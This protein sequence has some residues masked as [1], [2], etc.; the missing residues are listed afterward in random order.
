MTPATF[1]RLIFPSLGIAPATD[2]VGGFSVFG[3]KVIAISV[4]ADIAPVL[5]RLDEIGRNQA[6]FAIARALTDTAQEGRKA[7]TGRLAAVFDRP[8][9]FTMRAIGIEAARKGKPQAR[10]FVKDIQA[11]YLLAEEIGGVRTPR[12]GQAL[13]LPGKVR[14]NRYGNMP[15][16]LLKRLHV[17]AG[18]PAT[19]SAGVA[20]LPASA[21]ANKAGIGGYFRRA[22]GHKLMRLTVFEAVAHYR[23]RMQFR[24]TVGAAVR[25]GI[26]ARLRQRLGEA[27]ASAR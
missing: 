15:A 26:V 11:R 16:G 24:E 2:T 20:Y 23:A 13:V 7:M 3:D 21:P 10:I 18:Q 25:G 14:L 6:P 22:A 12:A 1:R 8:T 9:P 27:I 19:R 4:H 5:R 17:M